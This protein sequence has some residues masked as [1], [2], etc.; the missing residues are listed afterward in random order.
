MVLD[1]EVSA[2]LF[3]RRH[4]Q[5]GSV[6]KVQKR[7]YPSDTWVICSYCAFLNLFFSKINKLT[8]KKELTNLI[9]K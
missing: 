5:Q 2:S 4:G 9:A 1:R 6:H 7:S 3:D 8:N